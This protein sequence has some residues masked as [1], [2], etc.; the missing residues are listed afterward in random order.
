MARSNAG[1]GAGQLRIIG[2][3]WRGRRLRFAPA[4]GL[5]PPADR[6]RGTL[7]DWLAPKIANSRCLDLFAGSGALGLEALSRG[8]AHC[9]FVESDQRTLATIATHLTTLQAADRARCHNTVAETFLANMTTPYDVVFIDPPFASNLAGSICR[10]LAVTHA[11]AEGAL[12]YVE[13]SASEPAPTVPDAWQLQREK[14]S[15]EAAYR[16]FEQ[17]PR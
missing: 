16:L 14:K 5:R 2:G 1:R 6:R 10:Q 9:D 4:E 13:T 15:R 7:F 11:L 8:A 17:T 3:E 12:V